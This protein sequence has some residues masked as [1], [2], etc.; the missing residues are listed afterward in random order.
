MGFSPPSEVIQVTTGEEAPEGPPE[1]LRTQ[2][3]SSTKLKVSWASPQKHLWHG[4]VLGYYLGYREIGLAFANDPTREL[5]TSHY[6]FNSISSLD[7]TGFHFK[8]VEV[9]L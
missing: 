6:A 9:S 8:T 3:I 4:N 5:T 2:P 7:T 1:D